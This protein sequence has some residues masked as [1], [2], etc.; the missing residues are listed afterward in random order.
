MARHYY[1]ERI[2]I[3]NVIRDTFR[4]FR[5]DFSLLISIALFGQVL[6]L[7]QSTYTFLVGLEFSTFTVF[8][9]AA[10]EMF[11]WIWVGT[12][13]ISSIASLHYGNRFSLAEMKK[14]V[15]GK[16][17]GVFVTLLKLFFILLVPLLA[18]YLLVLIT[19][20]VAALLMLPVL[21]LTFYL[22]IK[23]TFVMQSA[24]LEEPASEAFRNSSR[25]VEGRFW[26][27]VGATVVFT[28]ILLV[29][30]LTIVFYVTEGLSSQPAWVNYLYNIAMS[31]Y[32]AVVLAL[33]TIFETLLYFRLKKMDADSTHA[34]SS[35][36]MDGSDS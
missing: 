32:G 7:A 8:L 31:L 19:P 25:L 22:G 15:G 27:V 14:A 4:F 28:A 35:N 9:L 6:T 2:G 34:T 29:V 1:Y 16:Y 10:A 12:A 11:I 21:G 20:I 13:L 24:T 36:S 23:Y 3:S 17:W 33:N 26:G 18:T 5:E 30:P